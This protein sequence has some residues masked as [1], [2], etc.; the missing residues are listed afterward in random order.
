MR[1][2]SPQE[3]KLHLGPRIREILM[4]LKSIRSFNYMDI[5]EQTYNY[6]YGT[7]KGQLIQLP[8]IQ[9]QTNKS[10]LMI[11]ALLWLDTRQDLV[12][13]TDKVINMHSCLIY[14]N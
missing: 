1:I 5:I 4:G 7:G 12:Q 2:T 13:M 10:I 8:E 14:Q 9:R 11:E 6:S 3:P